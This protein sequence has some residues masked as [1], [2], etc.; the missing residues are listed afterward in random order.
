[1]RSQ[2]DSGVDG[3]SVQLVVRRFL[4]VDNEGRICRLGFRRCS[5]S[6]QSVLKYP[7]DCEYTVDLGW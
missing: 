2:A 5:E 6:E 1:V 7:M 3:E 4:G